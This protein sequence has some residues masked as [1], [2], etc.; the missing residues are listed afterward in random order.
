MSTTVPE[1]AQNLYATLLQHTENVTMRDR[2]ISAVDVLSAYL[3]LTQ[4]L[5]LTVIDKSPEYAS[6]NA[7]E[8]IDKLMGIAAR[9]Q[10]HALPAVSG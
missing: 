10:E 6:Q 2:S 1:H 8:I 4:A 9:V 7:S 5:C 3:M